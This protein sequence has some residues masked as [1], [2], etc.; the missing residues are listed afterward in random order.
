MLINDREC[1]VALDRIAFPDFVRLRDR[2][3]LAA[4]DECGCEHVEF[5]ESEARIE[6]VRV[7][8]HG[9]LK[10]RARLFCEA[11]FPEDARPTSLFPK[12]HASAIVSLGVIGRP[13]E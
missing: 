4:A 1:V 8:L 10:F 9:A 13:G 12:R 5:D 3:L 6:E 2:S 7:E 11:D